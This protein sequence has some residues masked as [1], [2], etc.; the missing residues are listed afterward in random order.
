LKAKLNTIVS[1]HGA[2]GNIRPKTVLV[3]NFGYDLISNFVTYT[4]TYYC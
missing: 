4:G 1:K 3:R 2:L